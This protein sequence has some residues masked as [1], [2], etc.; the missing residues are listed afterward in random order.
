MPEFRIRIITDK[1]KSTESNK[2]RIYFRHLLAIIIV[3]NFP[4][5]AC[6]RIKSISR[7]VKMLQLSRVSF[8]NSFT[9]RY[10]Y[11]KYYSHIM[12]KFKLNYY[13]TY[14]FYHRVKSNIFGSPYH[15][16]K[17]ERQYFIKKING[18]HRK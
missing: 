5:S 9:Y 3:N 15:N 2:L 8:R 6:L 10:L 18:V 11:Y 4:R 16:Y 17:V 14:I 13:W 7:S 12:I 1:S